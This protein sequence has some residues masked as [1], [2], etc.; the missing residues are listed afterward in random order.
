MIFNSS[1]SE[2]LHIMSA[3][4]THAPLDCDK[5]N[6]NFRALAQTLLNIQCKNH[7]HK[8]THT[9]TEWHT[10][11]TTH[12]ASSH[13]LVAYSLGW[14]M[15]IGKYQIR[16]VVGVPIGWVNSQNCG[17]DRDSGVRFLWKTN[18]SFHAC[19]RGR[20]R[21]KLRMQWL[22]EGAL[23][24]EWGGWATRRKLSS[25]PTLRRGAGSKA[26]AKVNQTILSVGP[27]VCSPPYAS[28]PDSQLLHPPPS[29]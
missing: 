27:G 25:W 23:Q 17:A 8:H 28:W 16:L 29:P 13:Y 10:E 11:S 24:L 15:L 26:P 7:N 14:R 4:C 22:L 19:G 21:R 20:Q 1:M 9:H 18:P 3:Q 2:T 12:H 6:I 5:V